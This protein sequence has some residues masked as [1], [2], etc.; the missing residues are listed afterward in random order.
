LPAGRR[1]GTLCRPAGVVADAFI[2]HSSRNRR[3]AQRLEQQLE[4]RGLDVWLDDSEIRLGVLLGRELQESI[5]EARVF[6]LLWSKAAQPS[7]WV[8][9]EWLM[10]LHQDRFIVPCVLDATPLPQCLQGTIFLP[11]RGLP[12]PAAK[13]L[14]ETIENA[15]D[16]PT[17]LPPLM[18]A[19]SA[20]LTDAIQQI[21]QAQLAMMSAL[22]TDSEQ[23]AEIQSLLDGVMEAARER[24]P[25]DPEIVNLDGYHLKNAYMLEHWDAIQA[26]RSPEEPLLDQAEQ[27]FFET[28][29]L[30]PNNPSALN[31]LGN[32]FFF[33]RELH[34]AA[35]FSRAA[36]AAAK[37][38]GLGGYPAAEHDLELIESLLAG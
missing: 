16:G 30:D 31:G 29:A 8:N 12:A 9:S 26:G 2:S 24:W 32:I 10:A 1:S 37:K 20:E 33:E 5:L 27:R 7:R 4:A 23:A 21:G 6:V 38:K 22:G 34:A 18:R 15:D 3:S 28:L 17:T 35:F 14:A 13:K 11:L 19:E 25:L 36:I